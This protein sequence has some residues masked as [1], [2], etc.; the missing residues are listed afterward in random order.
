MCGVVCMSVFSL[1]SSYV[2]YQLSI[3]LGILGIKL[4]IN[5]II[6]IILANNKLKVLIFWIYCSCQPDCHAYKFSKES[7]GLRKSYNLTGLIL[8]Q[9]G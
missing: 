2:F 5:I 3:V 7:M 8:L 1:I 6:V 9:L 4:L